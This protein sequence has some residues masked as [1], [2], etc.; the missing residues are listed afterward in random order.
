MKKL[1]TVTALLALIFSIVM[2]ASACAT[3]STS[4]TPGGT[5][6]SPGTSNDDP[7]EQVIPAGAIVFSASGVN[8]G[9][10]GATYKDGVLTISKAGSYELSGKSDNCA[11]VI[12]VDKSQQVELVLA[13][14]ELTNPAG[15]AI[16]CDSADKLFLT[17]KEGT[18]NHLKDGSGYPASAETDGPNATVYSDD[19]LTIRGTGSL[20]V[21]ALYNNA[22]SSKNDI[23]IKEVT[24]TVDAYNTGI[25]GKESV[26]VSSG[27]L[28]IKASND[29]IK[30]TEEV[31]EGKGY[32]TIEGG[33]LTLT[34]GDD[35]LQA[36]TVLTVS[37]GKISASAGGKLTNAPTENVT[38]GII[39]G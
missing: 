5:P 33:E 28:T 3:K 18:S 4:G 24:L 25:R 32:V 34:A 16:Y 31:E 2:T 29:A 8:T 22:I 26:T 11:I 10:T 20:K 21:T 37:G 13:G 23:K 39:N 7:G 9:S 35:A 15:P 19:D 12:N 6:N 30:A 14:L 17:V 36:A 38:S 1:L 27:K